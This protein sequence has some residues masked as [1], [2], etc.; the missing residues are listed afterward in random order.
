MLF[1]PKGL[2]FSR[3]YL[4]LKKIMYKE[5]AHNLLHAIH[6][7]KIIIKIKKGRKKDR[8]VEELYTK[9]VNTEKVREL[10]KRS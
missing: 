7:Y 4:F 2:I 3:R 5:T 8:I 1:H 10:T 9:R 6:F